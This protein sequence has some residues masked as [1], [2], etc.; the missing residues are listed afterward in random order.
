VVIAL[1]EATFL[2]VAVPLGAQGEHGVARV[3]RLHRGAHQQFAGRR[4]LAEQRVHP[5][6][7]PRGELVDGVAVKDARYRFLRHRLQE[8]R[9][10]AE[11]VAGLYGRGVIPRDA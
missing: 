10:Y 1:R 4:E 7:V 11:G 9:Q 6:A 8:A 3:G 5:P 2:P